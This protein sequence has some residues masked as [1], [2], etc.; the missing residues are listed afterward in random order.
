[1]SMMQLGAL[2]VSTASYKRAREIVSNKPEGRKTTQGVLESLRKMMPGWTI[3]TDSS[4]WAKGVRNIEIDYDILQRMAEDPE[5]MVKFK[6]LIMDL[7]EAVPALEEWKRENP[8]TELT[9]KFDIAQ[10]GYL[11]AVALLRVLLGDET[12]EISNTFNLYDHHKTWGGMIT[13]KLDSLAQNQ[14]VDSEGNRSW[15]A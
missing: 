5:T 8:G 11:Q 6:A 1:M 4:E 9:F 15:M 13:R 12:T 10:N 2:N 7:E 14:V 3:V